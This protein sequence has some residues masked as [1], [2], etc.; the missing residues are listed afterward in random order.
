MRIG[1][2]LRPA[3]KKN[4]RR[5]GI[6][7]YT[8]S[9]FEALVAAEHDFELIAYALGGESLGNLPGCELRRLFYLRYPSRL[10]WLFEP[11]LFQRSIRKDRL[12]LFHANDVTAVP[13]SQDIPVLATVHDLIPWVFWEQTVES[14]PKDFRYALEFARSRIRS[15][16]WL[17]TSSEFSKRDISDRF[18]YPLER[19]EVASLGCSNRICPRQAMLAKQKVEADFGLDGPFLFYVG[20]S[21]FRKNL[22]FLIRVFSRALEQGYRGKLVLAGET[23]CWDFP[24]MRA[25]KRLI[26]K[27]G[28]ESSVV[29]PGYVDDE[30]LS[31]FYAACQFFVF[32]SLYEGF[33]I[34]VVEAMKVGA[35]L[36]VSDRTSIPEVA[37]DCAFYFDPED[38][39][40]FLSVLGEALEDQ[41]KVRSFRARGFERAA[42]FTWERTAAQVLA[43]YGKIGNHGES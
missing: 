16:D 6:G 9:L 8:L 40:D 3:L 28:V 37:G 23:F 12:N 36:I 11:Y 29:F 31:D 2:D 26:S 7:R 25:L 19:I 41:E 20:G 5:R 21:D 4:S 33:G 27:C 22:P 17:L 15:A 30:T 32:P 38:E 14:V 13:R 34:P 1:F 10:N 39:D 24:E 43:L 42:N 35:P 18:G